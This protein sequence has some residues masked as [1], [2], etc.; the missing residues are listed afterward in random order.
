MKAIPTEYKGIVFRSKSEA[1][2]ARSLDLFDNTLW[3]YEPE[4]L[5]VGDYVP[6]FSVIY[7]LPEGYGHEVIEY[8]PAYP[9]KTYLDRLSSH[10]SQLNETMHKHSSFYNAF[11]LIC[12]S[13]WEPEQAGVYVWS[14]DCFIKSKNGTSQ[15]VSSM[16]EA[17]EYRFDLK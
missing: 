3:R 12:V 5:K 10:F 15:T 16:T 2:Y 13:P 8:K 9:T 4:E 17:M 6:D 7:D 14:E 1:I 11:I